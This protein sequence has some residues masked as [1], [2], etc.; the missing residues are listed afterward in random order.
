[1]PADAVLDVVADRVVEFDAVA[2]DDEQHD[3]G[4]VLPVLSDGQ[5]IDHFLDGV[6]LAV[7]LCG[8]DAYAA[9]V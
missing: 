1:M 9:G 8:A 2:H 5:R 3:A 4:V 7:D 6:H